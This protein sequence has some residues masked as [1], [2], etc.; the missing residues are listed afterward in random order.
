[1]R[2]LQISDGYGE[3]PGTWPLE[4]VVFEI[5]KRMARM[6]HSVTIL[7]RDHA[8]KVPEREYVDGVN[9]IRLDRRRAC[10]LDLFNLGNLSSVIRIVLDG[11]SFAVKLFCYLS[12]KENKNFDVIHVH[13]PF[14]SLILI[15][16][17]RKLRKRTVF[18]FHSDRYRLNLI[19]RIRPP[20]FFRFFSPDLFLMKRIAKTVFLNQSLLDELVSTNKIEMEKTCVIPNGVDAKC[21]RPDVNVSYVKEK[22]SLNDKV[23]LFVGFLG[24]RKGVEYLVKAAN[25]VVNR[26]N[27]RDTLYV[28]VGSAV[29]RAYSGHICSLIQNYRLEKNTRFT[30]RISLEELRGLY[31]ASA[32]FVLPSLEE[33]FGLVVTEAMAS[34]KPVIGTKT[35]GIP[36]QIQ[37]GINGFIVEPA[38]EEQLAEKIEYLLHNRGERERMGANSRKIA[39]EKFDWRLIAEKYSEVY[40]SI[41]NSN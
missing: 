39:L 38:N 33:G 30:G 3:I 41:L 31:V 11:T 18:T 13:L 4:N 10:G 22:Y 19:S 8:E 14:S 27:L 29:S 35:G 7:E 9:I 40:R 1:M 5:S 32:L 16:L 34:G 25:I 37:N 23:I 6:G 26:H 36:M 21:F 24:K 17:K 28:F 12:R 20:I 15:F 2:I